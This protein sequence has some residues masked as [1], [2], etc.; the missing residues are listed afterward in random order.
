MISLAVFPLRQI[1]F[2][3]VFLAWIS[4]G[5]Q[6]WV[7]YAWCRGCRRVFGQAEVLETVI[8]AH[9]FALHDLL[10]EAITEATEL[11]A[12]KEHVANGDVPDGSAARLE[13]GIDAV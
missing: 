10:V 2:Q 4:F 3:V 6:K 9:V 1:L 8:L 7:T 11:I 13:R 5:A 12:A